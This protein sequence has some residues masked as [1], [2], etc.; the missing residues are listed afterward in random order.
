MK[1]RLL[2]LI[3]LASFCVAHAFASGVYDDAGTCSMQF[4]KLGVGARPLALGGSYCAVSDDTFGIF[5]NPAGASRIQTSEYGL[6][7]N[8]WLSNI[9]QEV[10]TASFPLASNDTL[11][12][13]I[14]YVHMPELA[15]SDIF[16]NSTGSFNAY[17]I[18]GMVSYSSKLSLP[19]FHWGVNA[20]FFEEGIEKERANGY[21]A[22]LG[23]LYQPVGSKLS[24]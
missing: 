9:S 10:A 24:L 14:L 20:K 12:L 8:M 1:K 19:G 13:G 5:W 22:D 6:M 2:S 18:L 15:G 4:L 7:Y 16:G 17:D 3:M 23:I 21:S 11:S